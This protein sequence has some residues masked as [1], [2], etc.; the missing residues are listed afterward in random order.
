MATKRKI[1]VEKIKKSTRI[2]NLMLR[3]KPLTREE[4]E[5]IKKGGLGNDEY[6]GE[7]LPK[8]ILREGEHP[9]FDAAF[10]IRLFHGKEGTIEVSL[11]RKNNGKHTFKSYK[12]LKETQACRAKR[13][14][15][16]NISQFISDACFHLIL[17]C[18]EAQGEDATKKRDFHQKLIEFISKQY[19][20]ILGLRR[21]VIIEE[22]EKDSEKI[23]KIGFIDVGVRPQT[24]EEI[25]KERKLFLED[26]YKAFQRFRESHRRSLPSQKNLISYK[27]S[28]FNNKKK[29]IDEIA[30]KEKKISEM[31][32][33][34]HLDFNKL[35]LI[36]NATE[37]L[38]D[39]ITN[40]V[41]TIRVTN[42]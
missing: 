39:F 16:M 25:E 15:E 8:K 36:F 26:L 38:N 11:A 42:K 37:N 14:F 13:I 4:L 30:D 35:R 29:K 33:K 22:I 3:G 9:F 1:P 24:K 5:V 7:G 28:C 34:H 23:T 41:L 31:L 40:A 20:E 10:D 32:K 21:E 17:A 12:G 6:G 2:T 27:F 19:R 18:M